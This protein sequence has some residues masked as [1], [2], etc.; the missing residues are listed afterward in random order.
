MKCLFWDIFLGQECEL[1]LFEME[2]IPIK[3]Q[4]FVEWKISLV[5]SLQLTKPWDINGK[6]VKAE[7]R[8]SY[9]K[10]DCKLFFSDSPKW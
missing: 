9:V 2:T 8:Y 5:R 3:N 4:E 10:R 1:C 6:F 7:R